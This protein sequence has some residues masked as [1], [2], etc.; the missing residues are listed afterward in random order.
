MSEV[1]EI[2]ERDDAYRAAKAEL[3]A[4]EEPGY[5]KDGALRYCLANA[6]YAAFCGVDAATMPGMH[7]DELLAG[8]DGGERD[9]K[10]RRSLV[11]GREETA[12]ID[13]GGPQADRLRCRIRREKTADGMPFIV[14]RLQSMASSPA[15][16]VHAEPVGPVS[17]CE[18]DYRDLDLVDAIEAYDEPLCVL[19]AA[20]ER[21]ACN[22]AYRDASDGAAT[23]AGETRRFTSNELM[24]AVLES[25][26]VGI[27][28]YDADDVLQFVNARMRSMFEGPTQHLRRGATLRQMLESLYDADPLHAG[29][30]ADTG[31]REEWIAERMRLSH[32]RRYEKVEQL[33]DGRWIKAAI[34]RLDDGAMIGLRMDVSDVFMAEREQAQSQEEAQ[35]YKA[36]LD[37]L[38][39]STY[40]KDE[41]FRIVFANRAYAELTG[42]PLETVIGNTDLGIFGEEEG[43]PLLAEDQR[44]F[45][46][47]EVSQQQETITHASGREIPLV[48]RKAR[49]RLANG[50]ACMIGTSVDISAQ[51]ERESEL[52]EARRQADLSRADLESVVDG[53]AMSVVVVGADESIEAINSAYFEMWAHSPDERLTG[54]HVRCLLDAHRRK[55]IYHADGYDFDDDAEWEAY[56]ARRMDELRAGACEPRE[57]SLADGRT[58]IFSIRELSQGRRL[59]CHFDITEQ[60]EQARRIA[61]ARAEV[62]RTSSLMRK[63]TSAMAQGLCIHD[64]EI[65]FVNRAFFDMSGYEIDHFSPGDSWEAM[66][67][68]LAEQGAY[69][70]G[71]DARHVLDGI[72]TDK[73]MRCSRTIERRGKDGRWLRID[74]VTDDDDL[75]GAMITTTTDVTAAKRREGDLETALERAESADKAKSEFLANMSH[76]IRTPMNGVL[77]M[78]ELLA[79]TQLDTRQR[80]FTDVIVKS[81]NALL[82]II[83]DILDFSKIDAGQ[84]ALDTAPFDLAEAIED[85]ATLVSSRVAEKDIELIVHT[86]PDLPERLVGDVGRIRQIVTNLL[87]NAVKFTEKGHVLVD[88]AAKIRNDTAAIAILVQDTG[89]GIPPEKLDGIFEKFSQ[90]DTSSTRRH[91]GSGLGLSIAGGLVEMMGGRIDVESEHGKGSTFIVRV[92][93]PV[94]RAVAKPRPIPVD[95]GGARILVIDDNAVNRGILMEQM[96]GWGFD[97]CAAADGPEGLAVMEAASRLGTKVDA[98]ILDYHMPGMNGAEVA[99]KLRAQ[100]GWNS[101]RILMLTSVDL[102]E[103]EYRN[104]ELRVDARLMKPARSA[105]LLSTLVEMLQTRRAADADPAPSAAAT[106]GKASAPGKDA[107]RREGPAHP[108]EAALARTAPADGASL[109]PKIARSRQVL[110]AEDNEVNQIVFS[111]ILDG[112]DL[113]YRIVH[114]GKEALDAFLKQAPAMILMD[115]SMPVMNGYEATRAI[116]AREGESGARTPIVGVTAH[117]LEGDRAECLEAGMDDYLSKPISPEKLGQK[118]RDW[119]PDEPLSRSA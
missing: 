20:G 117:A 73:A 81:G 11:F 115:V 92:D 99:R 119:L 38:P 78:A 30:A 62:E 88:V 34:Q 104:C 105:L 90:V 114:N 35:L 66:I 44:V 103:V 46:S 13:A 118:I 80:T 37:E 3:E 4:S 5:I 116:R 18:N 56:V 49:V 85:V 95:V 25:V 67:R 93:L 45:D 51:V 110:V 2:D 9:E 10:E 100:T 69:G 15:P 55:R 40:A 72:L 22:A 87:G 57:M 91:E 7:D 58:L 54:S 21:L 64:E 33:A 12:V 101:T 24:A 112:L 61:Q 75:D 107:D 41:D 23:S 26:D 43:R 76:E 84:M 96:R 27:V 59:I 39:N 74:T 94:D 6:A 36:V 63:A 108:E 17:A 89:I 113:E 1:R 102:A 77:G 53:L 68:S 47:G 98:V 28:I 32:R 29:T 71:E 50:R 48:T 83:N 8:G 42:R 16:E 19:D 106:E 109:E 86:A 31:A 79:R 111:Q 70:A 52:R 14:G 65:Q 60:K 97:A 82:T